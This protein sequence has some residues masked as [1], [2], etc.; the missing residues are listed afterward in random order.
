MCTNE[1]SEATFLPVLYIENTHTHMQISYKPV[2]KLAMTS[3]FWCTP[4]KVK[5]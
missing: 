5:K 3:K 1:K 4:Q 2:V